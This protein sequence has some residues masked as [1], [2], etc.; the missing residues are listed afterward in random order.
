MFSYSFPLDTLFR[1]W[2][3]YLHEGPKTLL[4]VALALMKHGQSQC[5]CFLLSK[6]DSYATLMGST[7][8]NTT[9]TS[10]FAC[11]ERFM[12]LGFENLVTEIKDI[13][14]TVGLTH[15]FLL[16][17]RNIRYHN[18]DSKCM[19]SNVLIGVFR[20]AHP[21]RPANQAHKATSRNCRDRIRRY[22][23]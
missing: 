3:I 11:V 8:S 13:Q 16:V 2:D 20:R 7:D 23:L 19:V 17:D 9:A 18:G 15:L 6:S 1:I 4:R 21:H 10:F 5:L 22:A 12:E 14:H